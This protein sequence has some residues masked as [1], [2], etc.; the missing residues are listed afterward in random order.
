LYIDIPQQDT[1]PIALLNIVLVYAHARRPP[2][3]EKIGPLSEFVL[4]ENVIRE[5]IDVVA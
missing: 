1:S 3:E 5:I 4:D 2:M